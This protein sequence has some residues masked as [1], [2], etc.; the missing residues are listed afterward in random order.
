MTGL[1][2]Y[3]TS[4]PHC[5]HSHIFVQCCCHGI[6]KLRCVLSGWRRGGA[7]TPHCTLGWRSQI[8]VGSLGRSQ[9]MWIIRWPSVQ[10]QTWNPDESSNSSQSSSWKPG[11][12]GN[13]SN[14]SNQNTCLKVCLL[15]VPSV[16]F[17]F[18]SVASHTYSLMW[19]PQLWN[20]QKPVLFHRNRKNR[21][22]YA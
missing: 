19:N 12:H 21:K 20:N 8:A 2:S 16:P 10:P 18:V 11:F 5:N 17:S 9:E 7:G 4:A 13:T 22:K 3:A 6:R 14:I 15:S 1:Q